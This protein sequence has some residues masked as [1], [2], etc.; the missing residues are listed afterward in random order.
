M[1]EDLETIIRKGFYS[2]I[3]NLNICIPFIL[4]FFV[5]LILLVLFLVLLS[6][7][8]LAS[9]TGNV[10]NTASLSQ[11][12]IFSTL[13]EGFTE[14][15]I[16]SILSILL[17]FLIGM[18]IQ[19]FFTAGA[20]AMAKKAAETGDAPLSDMFISGSKN[21]FRF[22]LITLLITLLELGG[23]IFIIPGVLIVGDLSTLIENPIA[24]M[25]GTEIITIGLTLLGIYIVAISIVL[26]PTL[27]A[28][29]IDGL[30]TFEALSTGF[31]FFMKNKMDVFLIWIIF[32]VLSLI[33]IL[34]SEY[35]D[36]G[37]ILVS[38]FTSLLPI[39]IIQPLK[40]VIW[41]RTYVSKKG[42]KLY[43]PFDLLSYSDK[44]KEALK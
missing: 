26:S 32:T 37:S 25:Q 21:A 24:Q 33:N 11:K 36:P 5:D 27:Y 12:E 19:S 16:L 7:L 31:H 3:R 14:N 44:G 4:N 35:A 34:V 20:I 40:T 28:L 13:L 41:T 15:I 30:G 6:I 9:N 2:W 43:D 1:H 18:F 39:V 29:V 8:L 42:Q 23:I 22:F 38:W 10:I 17:F